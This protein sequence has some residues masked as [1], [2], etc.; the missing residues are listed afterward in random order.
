MTQTKYYRASVQ[1]D[2]CGIIYT[3]MARPGKPKKP[4]RCKFCHSSMTRL[5]SSW[6]V[7]L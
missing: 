5:L 6:E 1:C 7:I 2:K 4:L 3:T